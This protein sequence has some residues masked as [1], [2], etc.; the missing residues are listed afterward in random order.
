[1]SIVIS[2]ALRK[3]LLEKGFEGYIKVAE[4]PP[5]CDALE[6]A[7]KLNVITVTNATVRKKLRL[8]AIGEKHFDIAFAEMLVKY[9]GEY[10]FNVGQGVQNERRKFQMHFLEKSLS[11]Y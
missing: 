7:K 9:F 8:W 5:H 4:A 11:S 6:I 10:I 3:W 2:E 1:M